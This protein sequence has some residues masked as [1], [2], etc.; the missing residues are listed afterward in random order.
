MVTSTVQL[1]QK[2]ADSA[3]YRVRSALV[4]LFLVCVPVPLKSTKSVEQC[5]ECFSLLGVRSFV[6]AAFFPRYFRE[7]GFSH[8]RLSM[9]K[10]YAKIR[11]HSR[12]HSSAVL[13]SGDVERNPGPADQDSSAKRGPSPP[14]RRRRSRLSI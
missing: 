3:K 2:M 4:L 6:S 13:L 7:D 11:A 1:P 5:N 14:P 12:Y 9:K 10:A 8:L